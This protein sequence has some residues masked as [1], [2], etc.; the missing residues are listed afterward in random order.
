MQL[1]VSRPR[2]LIVDDSDMDAKV[3]ERVL[4]D[5]YETI[6]ATGGSQAL[7][8]L[9]TEP[10]PHLIMLDVMM[11]EMSGYEV[12]REI[13]NNPDTKRIPVVF[14]SAMDEITD[15]TR[16]LGLGACDYIKKPYHKMIVQARVKNQVNRRI[17]ELERDRLLAYMK[18]SEKM[19]ALGTLAGGFAHDFNNILTSVM[20]FT[21][22]CM[23]D[24][25]S[26]SVDPALLEKVLD[27]ARRAKGL[28]DQ[29]LLFSRWNKSQLKPC[30][31]T[32][33][34]MAVSRSLRDFLPSEIDLKVELSKD[35]LL[36]KAD[37]AQVEKIVF[38]LVSNAVQ[39]MEQSG[40]LGI[41]LA[42]VDLNIDYCREHPQASP[43][44]YALLQIRDNGP[45]LDQKIKDRIF[46][47]FFTTREVGQGTG[48]GLPMVY[49]MVKTHGG[50]IDIETTPGEGSVFRLFFPIYSDQGMFE[51]IVDE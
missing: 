23:E 51:G 10:L 36:V 47:P 46:D 14:V 8:I 50:H 37:Q 30:D 24:A 20:G 38:N 17:A 27:G 1:R 13:M 32:Q 49:G 9:K 16:G 33:V 4:A 2:V 48:L 42:K 34:V 5:D 21:E 7:T 29:I 40:R 19:E 43:G 15:E 35:P 22:L 45:G 12:C 25:R 44:E 11:P 39:A 41:D 18:Q 31:F 6:R 28:V 3:L 26:Q